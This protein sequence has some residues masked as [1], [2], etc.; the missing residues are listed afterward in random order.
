MNKSKP[1]NTMLNIS[2]I[3][4]NRYIIEGSAVGCKCVS[5]HKMLCN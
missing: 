3:R 2:I 4:V 5:V 1:T